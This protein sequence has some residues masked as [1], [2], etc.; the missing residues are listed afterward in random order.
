MGG[1]K[2]FFY[3]ADG[4]DFTAQGDF[5]GHGD[6]A[7]DR[8]T[9]ERADDGVANGDAG[10]RAV[11]GDSALGDVHV[12]VDV[13]V[14]ILGQ[15]EGVRARADVG[16]GGLCGFLHDV[17]EFAG[18]VEAAL[19]LHEGGFGGENGAAD[20]GPGQ[21]SGEADFIVLFEP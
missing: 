6:V 18:Q 4:E 2:F 21:A 10:G 8:N 9:R 19:A 11:L 17:A 14:E 12:N 13:A 3:A 1:E 20:F 7:A 5:S 16:H 15:A